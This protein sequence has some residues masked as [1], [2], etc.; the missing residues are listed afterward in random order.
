M[1]AAYRFRITGFVR[2]DVGN[3]LTIDAQG[4]PDDIAQFVQ[5][6]RDWFTDEVIQDFI[7]SDKEP[8]S[9]PDF[10]IR[11]NESEEDKF[12]KNQPWFQKIKDIL[13]P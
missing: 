8:E 13:R 1:G 3:S 7:V 6:C 11:R 5:F 9:Y 2:Y 4:N 12:S 10:T